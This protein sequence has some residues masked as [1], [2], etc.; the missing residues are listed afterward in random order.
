MQRPITTEEFEFA[1]SLFEDDGFEDD[2]A[3]AM[4][5]SLIAEVGMTGAAVVAMASAA[6]A[7][8]AASAGRFARGPIAISERAASPWPC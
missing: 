3:S 6:R 7:V 2:G 4:S 8:S 1:Q 5:T